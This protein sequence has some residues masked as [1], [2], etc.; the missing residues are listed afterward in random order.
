MRRLLACLLATILG[1]SSQT[2]RAEDDPLDRLEPHRMIGRLFSDDMLSLMFGLV[3]RSLAA[4]G[5]GGEP[6]EPTADERQRLEQAATAAR[7]EVLRT[8][9]TVLGAVEAE[10]RKSLREELGNP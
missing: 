9:G 4:A 3:R 2:L 10:A 1:M 8:M 7:G 6:A 5:E